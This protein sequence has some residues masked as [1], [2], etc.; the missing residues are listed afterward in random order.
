[1]ERHFC[2]VCG[3]TVALDVAALPNVVLITS[4][5]LDDTTFVKPTRN[6][7]CNSARSWVPLT[8]DTQNFP[9]APA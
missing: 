3:S 2:P 6:I 8:Q 4:G 1:V 9:E 5:T 7:F